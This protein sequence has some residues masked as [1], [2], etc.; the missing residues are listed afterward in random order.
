[1]LKL[2]VARLKRSPGEST[3]FDLSAGL[4]PL[5]LGGERFVFT[6][7]VR[8][9]LVV[10]NTGETLTVEGELAGSLS[11]T[12]GRCLESY[13]YSFTAPIEETYAPAAEGSGEAI[14]FSGDLLDIT[15]EALK[16]VILSLPMKMLCREEC[17]GLCPRCGK[18]LN[19]GRCAC[20]GEEVDPRLSVLRNLLGERDK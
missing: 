6:G 4:P 10:S 15:P 8:A 17:S 3:R 20:T 18:N 14:P 12:C 16:S 9:G 13:N 2:D 7:P 5:E 1:M 11:L 19:E